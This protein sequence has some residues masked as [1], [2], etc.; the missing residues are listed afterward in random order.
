M[1]FERDSLPADVEEVEGG[2]RRASGG[3]GAHAKEDGRGHAEEEDGWAARARRK[4]AGL[5]ARG[6]RR[7]GL[8]ARGGR[9]GAARSPIA[10]LLMKDTVHTQHMCSRKIQQ[11]SHI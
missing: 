6:G 4:T 7:P 5:R 9:R 11:C 8:L 2:L 3:G 10:R 1:G